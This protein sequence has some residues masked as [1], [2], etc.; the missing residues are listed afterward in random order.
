[1]NNSKQQTVPVEHKS[2]GHAI[3]PWCHNNLYG[4]DSPFE[5]FEM[6]GQNRDTKTAECPECSKVIHCTISVEET[7]TVHYSTR[8]FWGEVNVEIKSEVSR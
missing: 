6:D 4:Y 8:K 3:C 2:E 7:R 1:M 5:F